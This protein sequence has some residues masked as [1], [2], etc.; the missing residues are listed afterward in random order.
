MLK[1]LWWKLVDMIPLGNWDADFSARLNILICVSKSA[2]AV[3]NQLEDAFSV[4]SFIS[5]SP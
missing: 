1:D 3:P 4:A 5:L 2:K